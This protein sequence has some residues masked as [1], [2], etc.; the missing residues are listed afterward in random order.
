MDHSSEKH[1]RL[2][3]ALTRKRGPSSET[4]EIRIY[5]LTADGVAFTIVIDTL[6][7]ECPGTVLLDEGPLS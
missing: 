5:A 2:C 1:F 3:R 6:W 7:G 4:S